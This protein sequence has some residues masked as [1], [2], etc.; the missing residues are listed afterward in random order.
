MSS[1]VYQSQTH[2]KLEIASSWLAVYELN[3]QHIISDDDE[4][5]FWALS[6]LFLWWPGE[7]Q[8]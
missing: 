8:N 2:S 7:K 4:F 5:G 1:L 3:V 6:W